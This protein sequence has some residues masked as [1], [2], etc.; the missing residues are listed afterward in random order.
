MG[1]E[2]RMDLH[3]NQIGRNIGNSCNFMLMMEV[4]FAVEAGQTNYIYPT[5]VNSNVIQGRLTNN[6]H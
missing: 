5:D 2:K 6:T 1:L 4:K 3:N